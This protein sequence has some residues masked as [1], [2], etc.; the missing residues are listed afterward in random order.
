MTDLSGRISN[1][2]GTPQ[3]E[4]GFTGASLSRVM[5]AG[6]PPSV[7]RDTVANYAAR[8]DLTRATIYLR[9][10]LA[11]SDPA[12]FAAQDTLPPQYH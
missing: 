7:Q 9:I 8:Q 3:S 12:R 1:E 5:L 10:I 11:L 4:P 2:Q 6:D